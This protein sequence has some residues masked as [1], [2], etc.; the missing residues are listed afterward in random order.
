MMALMAAAVAL[1]GAVCLI[2]LVLTVGLIRRLREHSDAL[3][4]LSSSSDEQLIATVGARVGDFDATTT[5]GEQIG[6]SDLA[7]E[8]LVGFFSPDCQ[9]CVRGLPNFI[10]R[11]RGATAGPAGVLAVVTGAGPEAQSMREQLQ[12]VA[13]VVAGTED[14]PVERAFGVRGYPAY[15]LVGSDGRI[16]ASGYRLEALADAVAT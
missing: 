6:R 9:P 5:T 13:Q 15:A 14:G 3:A 10:E 16:A 12:P 11:A 7:S 4:K 1:V 8:M 2:N